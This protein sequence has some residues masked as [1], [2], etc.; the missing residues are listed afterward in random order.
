[1]SSS[2]CAAETNAASNW[3]H[4]KIDASGE[5]LPEEA[6]EER[7][8]AAPGVVVVADGAGVEEEGEHA[9]DAL[10]DVRNPGVGRGPV[11]ALGEAG[12]EGLEPI[13]GGSSR[14][15]RK[16]VRPGGHRQRIARERAG[17]VDRPDGRDVVH[18]RGRGTIGRR[19]QAAADDLAQDRQVGRDAIARLGAAVGQ[20]EAGHHLVEDEEGPVLLGQLAERARDSPARGARAPCCRR[21]AR[22]GRRRPG[23]GSDRRRRPRPARR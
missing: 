23:R 1:M 13:V 5:H 18:D 16:V 10:D 19:R 7:G 8:V 17:L 4:G 9:A 22:A 6:G 3:L 12:R 21:P 2:V 14:R 20:A 15:S 11:E